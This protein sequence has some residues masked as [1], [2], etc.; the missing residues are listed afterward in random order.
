MAQD[1]KMVAEQLE[2][3]SGGTLRVSEWTPEVDLLASIYDMIASSITSNA[4]A[5]G[6]K[7]PPKIRG[8]PRPKTARDRINAVARRAKHRWLHERLYPTVEEG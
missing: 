7:K 2:Q 8:Y 5:N 6:V 4:A 3:R 1:D